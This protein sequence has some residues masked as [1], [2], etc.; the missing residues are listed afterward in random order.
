MSRGK[1][2]N[3]TSL[4]GR[5]RPQEPRRKIYTQLFFIEHQINRLIFKGFNVHR[6]IKHEKLNNFTICFLQQY[7]VYF[8]F[9]GRYKT[10]QN[11]HIV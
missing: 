1:H 7:Q 10:E 6:S 11:S 3:L 5:G 8:I 9:K 4:K 2:Y